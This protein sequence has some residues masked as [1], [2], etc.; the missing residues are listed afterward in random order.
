[1]VVV[2]SNAES[3]LSEC[4]D[5]LR[6]QTLKRIEV[7]VVDNGSTDG[8]AV[9]AHQAAAQDPRFRVLEL[10]QLGLTASRNAGRNSA[11]KVSGLC[12]RDR[13]RATYGL[14]Q[15]GQLAQRH[16]LRVRGGE[17]TYSQPGK[18]APA[19]LVNVTHDLDRPAQTLVISR[20]S[21]STPARPT[22]S[23][24]GISGTLTSAASLTRQT[25]RPRDCQRHTPGSAV[26]HASGSA[27]SS[28]LGSILE[29][30]CLIRS[31]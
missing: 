9:V 19:G 23:F 13:H 31:L 28:A 29:S 12:G 1:M 21:C 3:Y 27:A 24:E 10:P 18:E 8:T 15:L 7:I 20:L 16:W 25:A 17:R 5:S 4:L 6:S 11:R 14:C 22:A 30:C 26:R 2:A